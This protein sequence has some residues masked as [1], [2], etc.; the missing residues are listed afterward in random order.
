MRLE[1]VTRPGVCEW[2]RKSRREE[3]DTFQNEE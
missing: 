2:Q 1:E 3:K